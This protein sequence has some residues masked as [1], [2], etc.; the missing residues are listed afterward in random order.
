[1]FIII[2]TNENIKSSSKKTLIIRL[3]RSIPACPETVATQVFGRGAGRMV[4][5]SLL[6]TKPASLMVRWSLLMT[7]PVGLM[8]RWSL[9]MTKPVGL[10]VRWSLLM[11]KPVA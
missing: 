8:V 1:M 3:P 9:L 2:Y 4:R 10:M 6:M 5:W 11:T 7:K